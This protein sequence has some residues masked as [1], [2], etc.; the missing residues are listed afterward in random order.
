MNLPIA[1]HCNIFVVPSRTILFDDEGC[2]LNRGG[3]I[4][5]EK[6]K[7]LKICVGQ[8]QPKKTK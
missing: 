7:L 3:C 5:T 2:M 8:G 1:E 4:C 6:K